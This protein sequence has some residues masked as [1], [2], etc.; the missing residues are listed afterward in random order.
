M[1]FR[2]PKLVAG[3]VALAFVAEAVDLF[4]SEQRLDAVGQLQFAAGS[5]LDH[6]QHFEDA[7]RENVAADDGVLAG[8]VFGFG[9]FDHVLDQ[10]QPRILGVRCAIQAAIVRDRRTFHNFAAEDRGAGLCIGFNHL[11]H[12]GRLCVDDVV[13]QD[14]RERFI[15]DELLGLQNGVP[16]AQRFGLASVGDL[17]EL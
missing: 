2:K 12:A 9:L 13:G 10:Q 7:R 1:A 11:L 17:G 16:E 6:L 5:R 15:A 8:R 14:D 4:V 3:V